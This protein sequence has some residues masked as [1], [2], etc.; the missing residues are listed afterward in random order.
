MFWT[1][2][3]Q[4]RAVTALAL[5][6]K[7]PTLRGVILALGLGLAASV[8]QAQGT[9]AVSVDDARVLGVQA[10]QAGRPDIAAEIAD[11]LLI[12]NPS[13]SFGHFLRATSLM[14]LNHAT[15][16]EAA[17]KQSYRYAK[18]PEQQYQ[19]AHLAADLAFQRGALTT[20][21]WWLRKSAEAAPDTKRK[22]TSVAQ[23]R[24]VKARNP[25]RVKLAF[26]ARPSDNVNNGASGQYNIID[27]LPFVGTLSADA[28]AVKGV[29]ADG[30]V[31]LGYRLRQSATTETTVGAELSVRRVYLGA[32]EKALLG[33]DPG[34][35][36]N[37]AALTL[38]QDWAPADSKH[39]FSLGGTVGQQTYQ[40]G[41]DY[42]FFGLGLGHRLGVA[43]DT[44][45][46]TALD[47]EQRSKQGRT[48]GDRSATLRTSLVH[49]RANQDVLT[50]SLLTSRFDTNVQG[51]SSTMVG[52]QVGYTLGAPIG[53]VS[54]GANLGLQQAQFNGYALAGITVPGGRKDTTGFAEMQM[55]F[56]DI[57]YAGFAPL[58]RVRHQRTTS[59]VSRF[60]AK[61][62]SVVLGLASKF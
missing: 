42:T 45:I 10:V 58:L 18:S 33:G 38:E 51:R 62:T 15:E 17:A 37:R 34:F 9:A 2:A 23:F 8:A 43:T 47:V 5:Y 30:A 19:S 44:L 41:S 48:R 32:A 16:A 29:V 39:R 27:G 28:Q 3:C 49:Q 7:R 20:A 55:Q 60:S 12:L 11:A 54:L 46:D 35:G 57:S 1:N 36:S 61:E 40:S 13:D 14:H 4:H 53:P 50:V 24:A 31:S 52:A 6:R 56:N 21:Q 59:N 26:S 22:E 25:W